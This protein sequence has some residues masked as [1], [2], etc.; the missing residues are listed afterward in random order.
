MHWGAVPGEGDATEGPC[1]PEA[2]TLLVTPPDE[3][4]SLEVPFGQSVCGGG[5]IDVTAL[6]PGQAGPEISG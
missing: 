2:A 6:V 1:Q 3:R 4:A 5:H